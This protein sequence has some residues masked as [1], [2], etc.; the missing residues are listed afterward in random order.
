M[1]FPRQLPQFEAQ[2]Q[3]LGVAGEAY[4]GGGGASQLA[5]LHLCNLTVAQLV[6][7]L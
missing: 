6:I 1:P 2:P 4:G 3:H 7:C 5:I